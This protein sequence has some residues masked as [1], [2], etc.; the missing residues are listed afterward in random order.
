MMDAVQ[1][2]P[3]EDFWLVANVITVVVAAWW[4]L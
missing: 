3:F 4:M 2:G 1:P